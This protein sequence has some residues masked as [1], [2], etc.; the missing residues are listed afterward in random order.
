MSK[1]KFFAV[2]IWNKKEENALAIQV[3]DSFEAAKN[4]WENLP[5]E[6]VT[7]DDVDLET[8]PYDR[9]L[10]IVSEFETNETL[11]NSTNWTAPDKLNFNSYD[12]HSLLL[13]L[14]PLSAFAFEL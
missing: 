14:C 9:Y 8:I 4:V 2:E 3:F 5:G 12:P 11:T 7:K 10:F 6:V 1:L 13:K